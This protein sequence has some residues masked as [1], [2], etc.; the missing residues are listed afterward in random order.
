MS[1][2]QAAGSGATEH[3]AERAKDGEW[4]KKFAK[5]NASFRSARRNRRQHQRPVSGSAG[6]QY[7]DATQDPFAGEQASYLQ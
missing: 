1:A 5:Q 4:I 3:G 7:P 2:F 6:A